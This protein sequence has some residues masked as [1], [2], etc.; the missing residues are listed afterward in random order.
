MG[1][2]QRRRVKI[3]VTVAPELLREVDEFIEQ[4]PESDRSK[5]IDRALLLWYAEREQEAMEAQY[6]APMTPELEQELA[7]WHHIQDA[8]AQ[9][10]FS[11][12]D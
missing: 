8:A 5:V 4:H 12:R 7:D 2:I 9:R 11:R 6:T 1:T 10:L 3:S